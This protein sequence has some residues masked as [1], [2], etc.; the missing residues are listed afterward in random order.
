M[1]YLKEQ[2]TFMT[3]LVIGSLAA[4]SGGSGSTLPQVGAQGSA[5]VSAP[6]ARRTSAAVGGSEQRVAEHTL[7][8]EAFPAGV[9]GTRALP[10]GIG[11][12]HADDVSSGGGLPCTWQNYGYQGSCQPSTGGGD[13]GGI[14]VTPGGGGSGTCGANVNCGLPCYA[15]GSGCGPL[16]TPTPQSC[17]QPKAGGSDDLDGKGN[18]ADKLIQGSKPLQSL[19]AAVHNAGVQVT[20]QPASLQ[21]G[22]AANTQLINS[23]TGVISYDP[24]QMAAAEANGQDPTQ[25]LYHETD[26]LYYESQPGFLSNMPSSATFTINGT[27]YNYNTANIP[28]TMC[29]IPGELTNSP[30]EQAWEHMLIHNDLVNAFGTDETGALKEGLAGAINAPSTGALSATAAADKTKTGVSS[31]TIASAPRNATCTS[32]GSTSRST[33]SGIVENGITYI[34]PGFTDPY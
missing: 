9:R 25:I 11:R 32:G 31:R 18:T 33:L 1:K 17:L 23:T 13:N 3:L 5:I 28:C 21:A 14:I 20:V 10:D 22:Q 19:M 26:H 8:G 34:D 4:C 12:A 2:T 16:P 24:S 6:S 29:N 7:D 30:G 15:G 27:T